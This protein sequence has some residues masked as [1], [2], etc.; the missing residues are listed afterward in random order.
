MASK[1]TTVVFDLGGVL[2][3]WDPRHLYRRLFDDAAAMEHFLATVCTRAWI[4]AQD[5]GLPAATAAAELI[6]RHPEWRDEIEAYH[7]HWP[8]TMKQEIEGSVA[9]L[10]ELAAR[11]TALYVVSNFSADT[12]PHAE[13]RFSFLRHFQ[14]L[15]I[16][17]REKV[18]KPDPRIFQ[19]LL[20]RHGITAEDAIFID[21]VA[22]NVAAAEAS[23]LRGHHFTGPS[24]LRARLAADGLLER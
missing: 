17:G 2:I 7:A 1:L 18:K 5:E 15:V 14:G 24:V 22:V 9:I 4:E 8:E 16:S 3:D 13:Q 12:F 6:A 19:I 21:D 23:G 10:E 20:E 11:G